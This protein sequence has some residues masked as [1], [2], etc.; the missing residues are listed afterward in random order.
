MKI[1]I[2]GPLGAGK[3]TQAKII[4]N[5]YSLKHISTGD[6]FRK[7]I[8][9]KTPLGLR[10]KEL[11]DEGQLV[12]DEMTI[13]VIKDQ[14]ERVDCINGFLLDGFP[15]TVIQ[16][17]RFDEYLQNNNE[18]LDAVILIEVPRETIIDRLTG[19][20]VCSICNASYNIY[21][22]PT[23]IKGRCDKCNSQLIQRVD[24]NDE[25]VKYRLSKYDEES[26]TLIEYY[27]EKELLHVIDGTND[28]KDVTKDIFN[29]LGR[30]F[31]TRKGEL[32]C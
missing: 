16:A 25:T 22:C 28:I 23:K 27:K 8:L 29:I 26:K 30:L 32:E 31:K 10:T 1:I 6:I 21:F 17:I 15:R 13:N 5:M 2:L 12:P 14:L 7:N 4:S 19:R 18:Y 9:D 3:G 11:I 24:D 20:R